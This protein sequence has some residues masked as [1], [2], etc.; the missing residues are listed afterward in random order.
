MLSGMTQLEIDHTRE[1]WRRK[2]LPAECTR[3]DELEK[4]RVHLERGGSL[5]VSYSTKM[6]DADIVQAAKASR[7]KANA[8]VA[9]AMLH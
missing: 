4:A 1:L 9:A 8:A 3:I 2:R 5:L 6:A 7:D